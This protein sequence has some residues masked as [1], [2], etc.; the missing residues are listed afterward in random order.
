[1][2]PRARVRRRSRAAGAPRWPL[3][4]SL[5]P[6]GCRRRRHRSGGS[7]AG[8]ARPSPSEPARSPHRWG[9]ATRAR[10]PA[11]RPDPEGRTCS[12]ARS[13]PTTGRR[14]VRPGRS[15]GLPA[16]RPRR[17][18]GA[19]RPP[20]RF[21]AGARR[22]RASRRPG[23]GQARLRGRAHRRCRR[24]CRRSGGSP[25]R[26]CGRTGSGHA[27]PTPRPARALRRQEPPPRSPQRMSPSP[28]SHSTNA[29]GG[30][31]QGRRCRRRQRPLFC[32]RCDPPLPFLVRV[33][34]TLVLPALSV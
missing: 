13:R 18:H 16:R 30:C 6:S 25:L 31:H 33:G 32:T 1:M 7:P 34:G 28:A 22:D 14:R 21:A 8:S 9:D 15:G 26:W 23:T 19:R 3:P 11:M 4:R 20:P 5:Q 29:T 17:P 12:R 24:C 2:R 10:P 27:R